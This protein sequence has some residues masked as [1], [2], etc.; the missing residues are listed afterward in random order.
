MKPDAAVHALYVQR[1]RK[2]SR[3]EID[4]ILTSLT[5]SATFPAVF[6]REAMR[7]AKPG[8]FEPH[9]AETLR[10]LS[11]TTRQH[12]VGSRDFLATLALLQAPW[13]LAAVQ[14]ATVAAEA[15]LTAL[16]ALAKD[17]SDASYDA[18]LAELARARASETDWPLRYKLKRLGRY[19]KQNE[20]WRALEALVKQELARRDGSKVEG[21][22]A[23]RLGLHVPL[24]KFYLQVDGVKTKPRASSKRSSVF[25]IVSGN[26]FTQS[27]PSQVLG[28]DSKPPK[29]FTETPAWLAKVTK[30][31]RITW[32]WERAIV[33]S[34][35][36][37]RHRDAMLDWLRGRRPSPAP[38]SAR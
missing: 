35:L 6:V 30:A 21:S 23:Q 2:L 1:N 11:R 33:R 20:H 34:N 16:A 25:L 18:L 12:S 14:A 7:A 38:L 8:L 4:D 9:W 37:G 22:L 29:D 3:E 17:G 19:A 13:L 36:R 15:P 5:P 26:D 10:A 31:E 24:L 28:L 32:D 27:L